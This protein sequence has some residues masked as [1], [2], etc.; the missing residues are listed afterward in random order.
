MLGFIVLGTLLISLALIRPRV[1]PSGRA[2]RLLD[3]KAFR[4]PAFSVFAI[5]LFLFFSGLYFPFFYISAWAQRE[6]GTDANM[7][8]YLFTILNAGSVFGRIIPGLVADRIGSLNTIIPCLLVTSILAFAWISVESFGTLVVFSIFYGFFSGAAVSLPPTI[9]ASI[10]G[11]ISKVGT[12]MGMCF[13]FSGLGLLV[14]N[15]IAGAIMGSGEHFVRAQCYS[16]AMVMAGAF[17]VCGVRF[18]FW[19]NGKGLRDKI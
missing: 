4:S 11:D 8:F 16:G 6:L 7:A 17:M 14:G 10:V 18:I 12:W 13:T 5:G 15:P 1:K 9:V 3:L 2:R 19:R